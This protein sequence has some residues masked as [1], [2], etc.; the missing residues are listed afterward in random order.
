MEREHSA[1]W[2]SDESVNW[3]GSRQDVSVVLLWM[4]HISVRL[5][6]LVRS[7]RMGNVQCALQLSIVQMAYIQTIDFTNRTNT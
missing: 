2:Q 4:H 6:L 1:V 5:G 7:T 3:Y